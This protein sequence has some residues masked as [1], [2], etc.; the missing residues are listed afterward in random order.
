V[1]LMVHVELVVA[2]IETEIQIEIRIAHEVLI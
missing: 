1:S 2:W